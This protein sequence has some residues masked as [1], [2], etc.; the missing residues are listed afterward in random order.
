MLS[1]PLSAFWTLLKRDLILAF[2]HRGELLNPPLF[3]LMIVSLYP[4]G[5]SPE[6]EILRGIAPGI[7]WIAALLSA[8]FSLENLFKA[9][10]ADGTLEQLALSPHPLPW[11]VTPKVL[12]HWLVSGL[13]MLLLAPVLALL[14]SLSQPATLALLATLALGTP[15]LSLIG[16]V[17][18]ALTVGLRRGG[19]LLTLL[20]LPLYI[21]V[22]IFATG[23]VGAAAAGLP[24]SGQL[25]FLAALLVLASTLAPLAIAAAIR[26][27]LS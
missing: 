3:F 6:P 23:A 21:P 26:I 15:L 19:V 2:R 10:F 18:T 9:D 4:L 24:I 14:L 8:L 5:I 11:L 20:V 7:I 12:A 16:A 22:L 1:S 25:Y 13:P 17:G 27:S